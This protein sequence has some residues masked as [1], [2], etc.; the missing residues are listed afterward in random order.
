MKA[1]QSLIIM[2]SWVYP[3]FL[4]ITL[5]S[6]VYMS[7]NKLIYI[8]KSLLVAKHSIVNGLIEITA[9]KGVYYELYTD[10]YIKLPDLDASTTQVVKL[11]ISLLTA[12]KD[13]LITVFIPLFLPH[14]VSFKLILK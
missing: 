10:K 3:L 14:D 2:P 13:P 8:E 6:T 11:N 1:K 7:V 4:W 12:I 5:L 9:F